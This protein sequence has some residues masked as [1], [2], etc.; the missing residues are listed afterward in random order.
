MLRPEALAGLVHNTMHGDSVYPIHTSLLTNKEL[1]DRVVASNANQNA[2]TE[3][4]SYLL[5]QVKPSCLR[6]ASFE[7]GGVTK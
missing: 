6:A 7:T 4:D 3:R 2:D 1:L 5:S